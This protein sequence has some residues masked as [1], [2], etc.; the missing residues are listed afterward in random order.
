MDW[1]N[2]E[3]VVWALECLG[4]PKELTKPL[5]DFLSQPVADYAHLAVWQRNA[6]AEARP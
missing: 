5:R 4:F 1:N 6:E 3:D 2:P